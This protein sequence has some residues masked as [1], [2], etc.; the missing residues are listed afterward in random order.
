MPRFY[1]HKLYVSD[2]APK[3]TKTMKNTKFRC[4]TVEVENIGILDEI[5]MKNFVHSKARHTSIYDKCKC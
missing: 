4:D 5:S 2:V 3:S 1:R